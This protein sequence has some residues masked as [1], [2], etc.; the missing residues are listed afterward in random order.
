MPTLVLNLEI[1]F[2]IGIFLAAV[3]HIWFFRN[4][5]LSDNFLSSITAI[6]LSAIIGI[7]ASTLFFWNDDDF[8]HD[9]SKTQ[10]LVP[11]F[12]CLPI[13]FC[14]YFFNIYYTCALTAI[15]TA[16]DVYFTGIN[17][18]FW[19]N[20]PDWLNTALTILSLWGFTCGF[21]CIS[22]L[23]SFPQTQALTISVG[24]IALAAFHC[25]PVI[26]GCSAATLTGIFLISYIRCTKQPINHIAAPVLGYIIAWLGI[27]TYPEYLLPCFL[28]FSMYY[29]AEVILAILRKL[30]T[31]SEYCNITAN[32]SLYQAFSSGAPKPVLSRTIITTDILLIIL[33]L[34]QI[35]SPNAFS[36]P[37]FAALFC[38]WQQY[39]IIYW[40]T[41]HRSFTE[42]N[43]EIASNLKK[44][45]N[46][47]LKKSDNHTPEDDK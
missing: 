5:S 38:I 37:I 41:P 22:A 24:I 47:L 33:G 21:Y 9:I 44:S 26:L 35:S 42:I 17:F 46:E 15:V 7:T 2:I 3:T 31:I 25:A 36:I 6:A 27:F 10:Y 45:Y 19:F 28:I 30:T 20:A 11:L 43:R 14:A 34:F 40:Q 32:T 18:D 8:V 1:S 29:L 16:F 39:K 12:G 13:L 23:N 4:N